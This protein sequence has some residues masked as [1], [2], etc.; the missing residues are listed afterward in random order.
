[1]WPA[2]RGHPTD[3]TFVSAQSNV[4]FL[5][6]PKGN[7]SLG[8]RPYFD[9]WACFPSRFAFPLSFSPWPCCCECLKVQTLE[10]PPLTNL[11]GRG[12]VVESDVRIYTLIRI[13]PSPLRRVMLVTG[14][15][16]APLARSGR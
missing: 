11:H 14:N 15:P 7:T 1:M 2:C 8:N 5:G 3:P 9:R 13:A 10:R 12:C 4:H 6:P 16:R